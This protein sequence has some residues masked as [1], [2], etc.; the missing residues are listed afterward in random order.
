MKH[1]NHSC[2]PVLRLG[3]LVNPKAGLGGPAALKGSDS[4]PDMALLPADSHAHRR[5][6]ATL[7][8][9]SAQQEAAARQRLQVLTVAGL[10]GE[11]A[12]Q[13]AGL[14]A[15]V[16]YHPAMTVTTAADTCAAAQALAAAGAELLL[17]DGG[18]GTARDLCRAQLQIP[19]LGVPAGVKMHSGVFAVNPDSATRLLA[20]LLQ[21]QGVAMQSAEVRDLDEDALRAGKVR[22]AFYGE[23]LTPFD[24]QLLQQLKCASP[25]SDEL[26]QQEIAAWI[27]EQLQPGVSYLF[28]P[29]TTAAAV[30]AAQGYAHTLLG[31]DALRDGELVGRDLDSAAIAQL[32]AQGP[33]RIVLT[34]T[35]GQGML[36]GRGNQQLT[37]ALLRQVGRAALWV[38]ATPRKLRE[39]AGR[40]LRL[41]TGDA[42][43]DAEWAGLVAVTT[44]YDQQQLYYLS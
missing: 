43:L 11:A 2:L 12:V 6:V 7:Q 35:G 23:L 42:A 27:S 24:A 32:A 34:A 25:D 16:V 28:G 41:D 3:V 26:V 17:F 30:L 5:M 22:P 1:E 38:V 9:L 8:A 31:F 33:L 10:M 39:L 44:G 15:R 4:L 29:G 40:P 19:V 37:P 14:P 36:L 20:R 13:E 21:G 18:D